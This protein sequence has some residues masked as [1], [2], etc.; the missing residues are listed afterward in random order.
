MN[1]TVLP[2]PVMELRGRVSRGPGY[3]FVPAAYVVAVG[4]KSVPFTQTAANS[5]GVPKASRR[6]A[7]AAVK[8]PSIPPIISLLV[9]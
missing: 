3:A 8:S 6:R 7:R 1:N 9:Y 4:Q 2:I 5:G